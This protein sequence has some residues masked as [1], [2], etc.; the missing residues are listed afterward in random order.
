MF[1]KLPVF[2]FL[3][4]SA[5]LIKAGYSDDASSYNNFDPTIINIHSSPL[6]KGI[7]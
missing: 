5:L 7:K 1:T 2:L 4:L 3:I 6:D